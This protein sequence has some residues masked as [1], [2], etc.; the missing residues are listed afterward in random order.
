MKQKKRLLGIDLCRGIAAY[1]VI[2]VHSGDKNWGVPVDY[3][4]GVFRLS[5]Y[6][7]VPFFLAASFYF[8]AQKPNVGFS[9]RFWQSRLGRL[10]VPYFIWSLI[11]IALRTLFFLQTKQ[12]DRWEKYIS[13]PLSMIFFGTSSFHLYF[14][15][16][17]F[18]GS[19]LVFFL[20][21]F[22][23]KKV[24]NWLLI[25]MFVLSC[26]IYEL[27]FTFGD[28]AQSNLDMYQPIRLTVV[29]GVWVLK[30]LPYFFAAIILNRVIS[31]KAISWI[32]H[33]NVKFSLLSSFTM[34]TVFG[35]LFLP[36][37]LRDILVAY[38]LLLLGIAVSHYLKESNI[39][40]GNLGMCAFGIYLIHPVLMNFVKLCIGRFG[41]LNQIT[42][43]S[44]LI[45]SITT[46]LL[47][48]LTVNLIL[49]HKFSAKTL[50][51]V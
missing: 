22:S 12:L 41:L 25:V 38:S 1:A 6:F 26:A 40:V 19:F 32:S 45:I 7:A 2:V 24:K 46:F 44:I 50:L 4:A 20:H 33:N 15:P 29:Y 3:W 8:M 9:S 31:G 39:L 14:L 21:Y 42:V 5:F 35:R 48:W 34:A 13:D 28:Q 23:S 16:L 37:T 36:V 49:K 43:T 30:C 27:C 11:Y 47:S 51:G 18:V 10:I 17:L